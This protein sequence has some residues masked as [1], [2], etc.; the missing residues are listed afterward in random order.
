MGQK[1]IT[2]APRALSSAAL[3][4]RISRFKAGETDSAV[5]I[6]FIKYRSNFIG[7]ER[8]DYGLA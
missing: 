1:V 2:G 7:S 4:S 5:E 3:R 6:G 8:H